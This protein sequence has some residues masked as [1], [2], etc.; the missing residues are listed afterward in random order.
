MGRGRP[1]S[2]VRAWESGKQPPRMILTNPFP[3]QRTMAVPVW[4]LKVLPSLLAVNLG[5]QE[6]IPA[7]YGP[8]SD[9]NGV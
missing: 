3:T 8:T 7:A 9:D 5:N 1:E 4:G 2:G 6:A